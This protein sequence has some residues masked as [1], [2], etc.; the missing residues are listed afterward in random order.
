M[1]IPAGSFTMGCISGDPDCERVEKPPHPVRITRPFLM[2]ATETTND[3]YRGCVAAGVCPA[4]AHRP[5]V[6]DG[7][8]GEHPAT[9]VSWSEA[10]TFCAWAGG[11]LP[12]EAEWEYAARGGREG[13]RYAWG[14]ERMPLV[15]GQPMAN[16]ADEAAKRV[17]PGWTIFDG[18]DDGFAG[19][20]PVRSFPANGFGLYDVAGNVWEWCADFYADDTY[21]HSTAEDPRGP[22]SGTVRSLRGGSFSYDPIGARVSDRG[23]FDPAARLGSVGFRCVRDLSPR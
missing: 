7:S 9:W 16:V 10:Q 13:R 3:Q 17:H 14:D 8:G 15:N 6:E 20:S 4:P 11:R 2:A 19:T 12:S 22:S 23:R 1:A 21:A 18:Y 5:A